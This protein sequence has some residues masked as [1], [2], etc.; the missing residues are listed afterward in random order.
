[1]CMVSLIM[2]EAYKK[3]KLQGINY[4]IRIYDAFVDLCRSNLHLQLY[5]RQ[6]G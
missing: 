5:H 6:T 3:G 2:L 1:M 4:E